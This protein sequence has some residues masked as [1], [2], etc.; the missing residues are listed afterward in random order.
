MRRM[1]CFASLVLLVLCREI[2]LFS[3]LQESRKEKLEA[4]FVNL[5]KFNAL[6]IK[7]YDMHWAAVVWRDCATMEYIICKLLILS[8]LCAIVWSYPLRID[9]SLVIL[10]CSSQRAAPNVNKGFRKERF[11]SARREL[12]FQRELEEHGRQGRLHWSELIS[13]VTVVSP[14]ESRADYD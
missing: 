9:L 5:T 2:N 4:F 14:G 1:S 6:R 11:C 10:Q 7:S 3:H 13:D 12:R 8:I